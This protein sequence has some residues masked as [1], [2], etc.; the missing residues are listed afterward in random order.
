[1]LKGVNFQNT[2]SAGTILCLKMPLLPS[3]SQF[4]VSTLQKKD[5]VFMGAALFPV[6][7]L[8][9]TFPPFRS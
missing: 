1:M 9:G 5:V 2:S 8:P 6:L 3:F 4:L 7:F